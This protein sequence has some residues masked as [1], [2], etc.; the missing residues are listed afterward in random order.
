M[1]WCQDMEKKKKEKETV[2]VNRSKNQESLA[3]YAG[4]EYV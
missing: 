3:V 2:V 1:K 4:V